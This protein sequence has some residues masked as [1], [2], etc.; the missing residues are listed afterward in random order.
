MQRNV[1]KFV[2]AIT[3]QNV[4]PNRA[5]RSIP[6]TITLVHSLV[7]SWLSMVGEVFSR[8]G[9]RRRGSVVAGWSSLATCCGSADCAGVDRRW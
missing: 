6:E 4:V 5:M 7:I 2:E 3:M 8:P 9:E 1:F